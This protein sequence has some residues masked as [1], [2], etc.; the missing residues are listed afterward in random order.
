[1][2]GQLHLEWFAIDASVLQNTDNS[3]LF[4]HFDLSF[5][6]SP[7]PNLMLSNFFAGAE[8]ILGLPQDLMRLLLRAKLLFCLRKRGEDHRSGIS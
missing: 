2:L 7:Q 5:S 1:M 8:V 6:K 4:L 3:S